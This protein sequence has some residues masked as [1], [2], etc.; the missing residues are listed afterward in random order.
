MFEGPKFL[1]DSS[2]LNLSKSLQ[3]QF[4]KPKL[5]CSW[6]NSWLHLESR[7]PPYVTHHFVKHSF[8]F[9]SQMEFSVKLISMC[10]FAKLSLQSWFARFNSAY[11][12]DQRRSNLIEIYA[13]CFQASFN[14]HV[15]S[16]S[17]AIYMSCNSFTSFSQSMLVLP[18][19]PNN[20]PLFASVEKDWKFFAKLFKVFMSSVL[21]WLK[22][23]W[24]LLWLQCAK[25]N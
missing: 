14:S 1:G 4:S 22:S 11:L 21:R 6:T 18:H 16:H 23:Q 20:L 10:L 7:R 24:I 15:R 8:G 12:S 2:N 17:V 13:K 5:K 19:G 25:A 9:A 3:L